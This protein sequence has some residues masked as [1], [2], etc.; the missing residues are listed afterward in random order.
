MAGDWNERGGDRVLAR[1]RPDAR[2]HL[3]AGARRHRR[4][5]RRAR[6][7]RRRIRRASTRCCRSTSRST[8]RSPSTITV[9]R[10]PCRRNMAREIRPQPRALPLHEAGPT[11]ALEGRARASAGH[12]HHAHASTSSARDAWSRPRRATA[13]HGRCPDTL[14]GTD[15]HTPMINGIGVLGW[16]VGGARGAERDVRH[17]G[18]A[19]H[20]GRDRRA[21][22]A[23]RFAR[24]SLATDLALTVTQRLR[25]LGVAGEFVE[26]FGPG[27]STLCRRRARR[28]RQHGAGV[29][30]HDGLLPGRRAARWTICARPGRTPAQVRA[31]RGLR[32]RQRALV[33]PGGR[34]RATRDTI[35]IDLATIGMQPRRAAPAAGRLLAEPTARRCAGARDVRCGAG[36][37]MPRAAGRRHPVAIAAITSCTNTSDPR[38][39]IAAGPA[40]RARRA[41]SGLRVPSLGEDLA[42]RRARRRPAAIC[43]APG[44][45]RIWRR[46]ASTSSA[47]AAR[48]ASATPARCPR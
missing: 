45:S 40:S 9:R 6:R 24:A 21:A 8:T 43:D 28:R 30:R 36:G 5:A 39:L 1:P 26:F 19:A 33:R 31:G 48:P 16:G 23:A 38:L 3:R 12:R 11:R 17:A 2:H 18:D 20:P 7:G 13:T 4:D 41:G 44:C 10:T 37:T 34:A 32:Q 42:R 35:E 25:E 15:S 22:H 27:V 47:T 14:I 29:R 46:S